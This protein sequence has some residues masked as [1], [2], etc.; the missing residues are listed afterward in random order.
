MIFMSADGASKRYLVTGA[1]GFVGRVLCEHLQEKGAEVR[2][3]LRQDHPGP[4]NERILCDLVDFKQKSNEIFSGIDT[5]FY[6]ASIA[7]NKSPASE[8]Q[9]I[10]VDLCLAFAECAISNGIKRFVYVSSTKAM[11]EPGEKI[12]DETFI[13]KP[14]GKYGLSKRR[15]EEELLALSGFEHLVIIRPCLIYGKGVQGN[16]LTML[17]WMNKGIFPVLAQT[18]A[19]RSMVSVRNVA[20]ALVLAA[21]NPIAHRKTYLLADD[22][23]CSLHEIENA[24]RNAFHNK[25]P[26]G[27]IPA[28]FLDR[29]FGPACYSSEKI[30]HE[31]GWHPTE[32]FFQVLPE[33]VKDFISRKHA[34]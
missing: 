12:V 8:Y 15:A 30:R 27:F 17:K 6:L 24:M 2:A 14:A 18:K 3:L 28:W 9:K 7:H 31:L 1:S 25:I 32:N 22:K 20:S 33:M 23:P 29:L 5:V 26:F 21:N 19:R 4:W 13:D 11:A 16:L 10:N 34:S